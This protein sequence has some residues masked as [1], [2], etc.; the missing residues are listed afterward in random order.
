[1]HIK[2]AGIFLISFHNFS[3]SLKKYVGTCML[4]DGNTV[5]DGG[6][7]EN[8]G[9]SKKNRILLP[10]LIGPTEGKN[11]SSDWEKLLKYK[12]EG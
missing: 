2:D 6:R 11:C 12:A 5:R 1:M 3:I 4:I 10:K 8:V 7:M 9:G